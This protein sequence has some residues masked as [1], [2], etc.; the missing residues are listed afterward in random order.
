MGMV[1]LLSQRP[2]GRRE[3]VLILMLLSCRLHHFLYLCSRNGNVKLRSVHFFYLNDSTSFNRQYEFLNIRAVKWCRLVIASVTRHSLFHSRLSLGH[4]KIYT[5]MEKVW[6]FVAGH[7]E[8]VRACVC[9]FVYEWPVCM[10]L[11]VDGMLA[12][13]E[14]SCRLS[15]LFPFCSSLLSPIFC[16]SFCFPR[17]HLF[18]ATLFLS[19]SFLSFYSKTATSLPTVPCLFSYFAPRLGIVTHC[20]NF[21]FSF[22]FFVFVHS[23][24]S[25]NT[26]FRF[27]TPKRIIL[28]LELPG[29]HYFTFDIQSYIPFKTCYYN[30]I[31][32]GPSQLVHATRSFGKTKNG[33][34]H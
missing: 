8:G 23:I 12:P 27:T 13:F 15:F 24:V 31:N 33:E 29:L 32:S 2:L 21:S 11:C 25:F 6:S 28:I 16:F 17:V 19:I 3:S 20:F 5:S 30:C 10:S 26:L 4:Q 14:V 34:R 22:S 1:P 18:S 7:E 9:V